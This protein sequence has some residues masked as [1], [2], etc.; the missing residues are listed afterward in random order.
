MA[1][2]AFR[3]SPLKVHGI[4]RRERHGNKSYD[5]KRPLKPFKHFLPE[6]LRGTRQGRALGKA[7]SEE[8]LE[9]TITGASAIVIDSTATDDERAKAINDFVEY[10]SNM[11][12][13]R[14]FAIA[15]VSD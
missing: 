4:I 6:R 14:I 9:G 8:T 5:T 7:L 13:E 11:D 2:G 1:H 3:T 15:V 10:I 12:G